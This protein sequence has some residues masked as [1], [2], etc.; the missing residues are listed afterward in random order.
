MSTRLLFS[1]SLLLAAVLCGAELGR[2]EQTD[3]T[4]SDAAGIELFEK[5][6]RPLLVA[7]CYEC[8]G[9]DEQEN[10][11]RLDRY[12][13]MISGGAAGPAVVPGNVD[14]SLL[15]TAVRYIDADLQMPPDEK[16]ND[17]EIADLER[18]V[19]LG[20]PHPNSD[21]V[22]ST[23]D[24]PDTTLAAAEHWAFQP[25]VESAL[26]VVVDAGWPQ[27]PIDAFVLARLEA[28]GLAPAAAADR[29]TLIRRA[30][31]DLIGLPPTGAEVAAFVD[32]PSPDAYANVIDRLLAS[33]RYGERWGRHWLDVA[34]YADSNGLDENVAQ[35][36]AWRYRDYVINALNRDKPYDEFVREQVAGD[37]I[38]SDD[39]AVRNER[40]VATGFV[41]LGPKVLAEVD[42]TKMEM[43][44]IDEQIDTIGKALLGLT[45]GCA[46]CHDHKFDPV[47]TKDYYALAG[48]FKSTHTMDSLATIARW[49][50]HPLYD[51]AYECE[52]AEHDA[53]TGGKKAAID[54][55]LARATD[56]LQKELGAGA[57]L[58]EKPEESFPAE[59][60]E[61]L[62]QQREEL[63][64][65]EK[66]AP[67]GPSAMGVK[68]GEPVD[69]AVH[70][71][72]SHLTLGEIVPRRMP[73]VLTTS[74]TPQ[75]DPATSGRLA[76]AEWLASAAN[77]LSARV[78][79]NRIWR[80]HFGRGLVET[81]DNFGLKGSRPTDPALLDWLT[82]NFIR[83]GWSLKTLHRQIMLSA[84]YQMSSGH[85]AEA[86]A[87]DPQNQ[88]LWRF[89]L[90]RL[91]AEQL[92]DALLAVSGQLDL[93]MGGA[94]LAIE[95]RT[96]IFDHTSKDNTNYESVRRSVYLPVVRN[97]LHD[98]FTLFDYSDASMPNGD[99]NTSTV[100]SQALY[101]MNGE[102]VAA[103]SSHLAARMLSVGG[104]TD[105][106]H[107]RWLY[108]TAIGRPPLD[109]EV[110]LVAEYLQRFAQRSHEQSVDEPAEDS[111]DQAS[112]QLVCQALLMSS[113]FV[114]IR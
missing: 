73:V 100:A 49:H 34:R 30:T 48:V 103:A 96:F 83:D 47:S 105:A 82:V 101:L 4:G 98:S 87:V 65:L 11:L 61:Q 107:T 102:F 26:P 40:L 114:Y 78:M 25:P 91:E 19:K 3:A 77:P 93:T 111:R 41:S 104:E 5:R 8:H 13:G 27:S 59:T 28:V 50:E 24:N 80:W 69:V 21:S 57:A 90:H 86:A 79:V 97:H 35:A 109:D 44:I 58:P 56:T 39:P 16:L 17:A 99:R 113:E 36:N 95:N 12:A 14:A 72:G 70:I 75:V 55:L 71:R 67:V 20:A 29:R 62:K 92:R 42:K 63:A 33:P 60:Q 110:A 76:L 2:A 45:F 18:W 106:E 84:T 88:R 64:A 46:R 68:E 37:L 7:R 38:P 52:K 32:D 15:V 6:I 112:W 54:E 23:A 66:E 81:T 51:E 43:D 10:E 85:N 89:R 31:F 94:P 53:R 22:P 108:Q 9:P 74:T 1:C